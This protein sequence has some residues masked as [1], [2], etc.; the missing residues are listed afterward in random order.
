M[1]PSKKKKKSRNLAYTKLNYKLY[2]SRTTCSS[3]KSRTSQAKMRTHSPTIM[4]DSLVKVTSAKL[5]SQS[6]ASQR[7]PM[8]VRVLYGQCSGHL[9]LEKLVM[10]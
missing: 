8:R 9:K 5:S 10:I 7:W 4:R 1:T 6:R 2:Q 3:G